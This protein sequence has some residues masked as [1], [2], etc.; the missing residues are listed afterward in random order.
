MT[1]TALLAALLACVSSLAVSACNDA[2]RG[3]NEPAS[4]V[5]APSA[6]ST[7]PAPSASASAAAPKRSAPM[8]WSGAYQASPGSLYVYDGGEWKGVHFRGDDASVGLGEGPLSFTIDPGTRELRGTASG[9]L[10]DVILA[11]VVS[12]DLATDSALSFS[13]LRKDPA[14]HGLTGTGV[15]HLGEHTLTGTMRLSRGD[16]HVIRDVTF[17][18]TP[19]P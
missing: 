7:K 18:L 8:T 19:A 9:P 16:A 11:G 12:R 6:S 4:A 3:G 17:S 2:P 15:G 14:D 1:R 10:G 5:P 13:V